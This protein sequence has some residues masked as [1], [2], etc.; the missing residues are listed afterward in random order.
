M[1]R[2]TAKQAMKEAVLELLAN[3]EV[4]TLLT[5]G[6]PSPPPV[7]PVPPTESKPSWW[8]RLKGKVSELK[9]AVASPGGTTIAALRVLEQNA[10]RGALINAVAASAERSRQLA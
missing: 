6:R 10:V 7:V 2:C 5:G 3:P 8:Q 9:D 1:L 4:R